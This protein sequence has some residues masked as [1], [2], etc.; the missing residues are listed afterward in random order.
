MAIDH[1]GTGDGFG[2]TGRAVA[3]RGDEPLDRLRTPVIADDV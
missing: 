1:V 2:D 3:P